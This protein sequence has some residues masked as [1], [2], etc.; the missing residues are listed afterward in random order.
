MKQKQIN[1]TIIE[2][3]EEML[4]EEEKSDIEIADEENDPDKEYSAH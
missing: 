1:S 3:D 4:S 2:D